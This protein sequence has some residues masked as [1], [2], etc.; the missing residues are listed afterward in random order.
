MARRRI[1]FDRSA[2]AFAVAARLTNATQIR[3]VNALTIAT[4][5]IDSGVVWSRLRLI[6]PFVGATTAA[7][8]LNLKNTGQFPITWSGAI[9]HTAMGAVGVAGDT[10][11]GD[12]GHTP[13]DNEAYLGLYINQTQ[14]PYESVDWGTQHPTNPF[15][16]QTMNAHWHTN[17]G[18]YGDIGDLR[19][20][21]TV[22]AVPTALG[23]S[24]VTS[25][26]NI[27]R[28]YKNASLLTTVTAS[29]GAV[30]T[31]TYRLFRADNVVLC[32][33]RTFGCAVAGASLTQ[34]QHNALYA[35]IQNY[36]TALGRAV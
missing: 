31:G 7:H 26:S 13:P 2:Y 25:I 27:L 22:A 6:Y 17:G 1:G 16:R 30:S 36:Q 4:K 5:A 24:S 33:G 3:A 14:G 9:T 19:L 32:P 28:L 34:A 21:R 8:S 29:A 12:T 23:W 15:V 18:L 10:G 35:A 11:R 20:G